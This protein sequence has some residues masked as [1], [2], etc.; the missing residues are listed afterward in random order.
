MDVFFKNKY[1]YPSVSMSGN[2]LLQ[3]I[4]TDQ[5]IYTY[6]AEKEADEALHG[7][8]KDESE[9]EWQQYHHNV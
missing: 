2:R 6:M 8:A 3:P 1:T 7:H 9:V 4:L 5:I